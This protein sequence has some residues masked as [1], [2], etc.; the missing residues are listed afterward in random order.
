MTKT[1][2]QGIADLPI[3]NIRIIITLLIVIATA[4]VHLTSG[5]DTDGNWLMFLA[6]MAG[7]DAIQHIG[8][9]ATT[10]P[11]LSVTVSD[12]GVPGKTTVTQVASPDPE[13]PTAQQPI[14]AVPT[15]RDQGED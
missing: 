9:R 3:T 15:Q 13:A 10:K 8:K 7:I 5:R 1:W 12:N 2:T 4:A 11:E 14:A 6:A